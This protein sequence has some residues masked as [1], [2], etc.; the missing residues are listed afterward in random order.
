VPI[1]N[2]PHYF[3]GTSIGVYSTL[4]LNGGS[5][6]WELEGVSA[7]G[8][9]VVGNITSRE[10]D[11]R[12]VV[13]THGRGIFVGGMIA[14]RVASESNNRPVAFSLERNYPNPFN[15]STTIEYSLSEKSKIK[16]TI[17]NLRGQEVARLLNQVQNAGTHKIVWDAS[18]V[19]S[20]VYLYKLQAGDF[21]QTRKMVLLK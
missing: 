15:P 14:V 3:L 1:S 20:G 8:N 21:V 18:K 5:T 11:G 10:S 9:V 2:T 17:Y 19:A 7:M 6:V 4:S 13:G 12:V 16:L